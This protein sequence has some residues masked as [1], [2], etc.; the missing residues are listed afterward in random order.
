ML[1][2]SLP[3]FLT[4]VLFSHWIMGLFGP[5]FAESSEALVILAVGQLA[6]I[7]TGSVVVLLTM[8]GNERL[9]RNNVTFYEAAF[10]KWGID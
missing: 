10:I 9:V 2:S 1:T 4:F 6:N 3:I 8:S 5:A 7:S